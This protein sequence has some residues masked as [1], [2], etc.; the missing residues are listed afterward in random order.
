[1]AELPE[2]DGAPLGGSDEMGCVYLSLSLQVQEQ[3]TDTSRV[4]V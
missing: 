4:Q 3:A 1:M 2:I